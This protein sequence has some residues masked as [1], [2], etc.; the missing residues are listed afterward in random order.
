MGNQQLKHCVY[1]AWD[2]QHFYIGYKSYKTLEEFNNYKTSSSLKK[3]NNKIIIREFKT[4]RLAL[5]AEAYIIKYCMTN[6]KDLCANQAYWHGHEAM[7]SAAS[8]ENRVES[9]KVWC[10]DNPEESSKRVQKGHLKRK[11]AA[12]AKTKKTQQQNKV[13][14]YSDKQRFITGIRSKIQLRYNMACYGLIMGKRKASVKSIQSA[15]TFFSDLDICLL[16]QLNV[17]FRDYPNGS[18]YKC[19]EV[20]GTAKQAVE[21]IVQSILKRIAGGENELLSRLGINDPK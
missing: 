7:W 21:D 2:T 3:F 6:F 13:G 10:K 1:Y 16:D 18:R 11:K 12:Y 9:Y 14:I 5:E 19:T 8:I 4:R 15:F 20:E 17:K